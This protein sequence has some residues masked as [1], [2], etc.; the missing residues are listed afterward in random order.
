MPGAVDGFD[1]LIRDHGRLALADC[2]APAIYYARAGVPVAP[3]AA[4]DW[5]NNA[6]RLKGDA[7]K[8]FL[9]DDKPPRPGQLFA[10]PA[11]AQALE[12]IGLVQSPP[13]GMTTPPGEMFSVPAPVAPETPPIRM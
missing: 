1:R 10:A 2:L 13:G 8:Y 7:R 9:F 12:L 3:R 11:Q 5:T 6:E 4:C